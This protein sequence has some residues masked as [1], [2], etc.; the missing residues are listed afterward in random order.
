MGREG[1]ND[2]FK[3][4][5]QPE[6]QHVRPQA[7]HEIAWEVPVEAV[8]VPSRGVI[9]PVGSPLHGKEI[10]EIRAMT[11][12]EE[13]ILTSRALIK[14]GTVITHLIKSCL[15]N[16][17]VNVQD[18]IIGDRNALMVSVRITG[19]GS[20]YSASA[21]CG[22]CGKESTQAFDLSSLEIKRLKIEPV[23]QGSNCFEYVLPVSGRRVH[24]KFLTGADEE[25]MQITESRRKQLMP[26]AL[27]ENT[28]TS[29]LEQSIIAVD[30]VTDRAKINNFIRSMPALDSKKL[31]N[32]MED[33]QPGIDLSVSM[34]CP[35]CAATTRV[36]LPF[37][38]NFF[39]PR[40]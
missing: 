13:D 25:E 3:A 10:L 17:D 4:D 23:A 19:Y 9:Y 37:G 12:K 30:G 26:D 21:S 5:R 28:V 39:W 1:K 11:A 35:Y 40:E 15:V 29:R 18:M 8:P 6:P 24:F 2:I 22:E 16:K 38:P 7:S 14:Q 31:R 27:V 32:F 34:H 33:N 20:E 36:S